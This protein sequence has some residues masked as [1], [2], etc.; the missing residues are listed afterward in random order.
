MKFNTLRNL[1]KFQVPF[2]VVID[3]C[4]NIY[5]KCMDHPYLDLFALSRHQMAHLR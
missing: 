3:K 2:C 5:Q 1:Y 4:T